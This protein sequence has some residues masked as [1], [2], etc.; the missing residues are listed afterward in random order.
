MVSDP[1]GRV[2]ETRSITA[3]GTLQLGDRYRPGLYHIQL[4]QG[5]NRKTVKLVKTAY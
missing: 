1:L 4:I 5:K 3:D 2:V